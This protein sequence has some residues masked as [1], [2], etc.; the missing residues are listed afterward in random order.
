MEIGISL[1]S[2]MGDRLANLR[3]ARERISRLPGVR[4]TAVSPVYETE[5]V[6]VSPAYRHLRFLNAVVVAESEIEPARLLSLFR[7]IEE[8]MGR[9]RGAD[10][11][12]PRP[13]DIDI[14]YADSL[15]ERDGGDLNLPHPRWAER[16]FVVAPLADAR[17]DLVLPG[18]TMSV[19]DILLTLPERPAVV[20]F[21]S[22][23]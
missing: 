20:L 18:Q 15:V 7:R 23:W 4:L 12:E 8:D 2:N 1:G 19:K 22:E 17:P 13:I 6:G 11:N 10:R 3:E 21:S 14:I 16:R 9:K 5:P